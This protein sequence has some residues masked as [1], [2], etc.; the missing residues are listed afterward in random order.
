MQIGI[1]L[2]AIVCCRSREEAVGPNSRRLNFFTCLMKISGL[3]FVITGKMLSQARIN[4]VAMYRRQHVF[5][6]Q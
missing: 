6:V 1:W 5:E 3:P 4:F 2:L